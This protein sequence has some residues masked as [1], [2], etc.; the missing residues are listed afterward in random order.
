MAN[1]FKQL[2]KN[3]TDAINILKL[4]AGSS[5]QIKAKN[6]KE[7]KIIDSWLNVVDMAEENEKRQRAFSERQRDEHGKFIKK[8]DNQ[9]KQFLGMA[10]SVKSLFSSAA[11]GIKTSMTSL[12]TGITKHMSNFF[13]ALKSHVTSLFGEESEWFGILNSIKDSITGF[14]SSVIGWIWKK[15]PN[16]ASKMVK[17]LG[18]MYKLQVKEMK[19]GFLDTDKKKKKISIMGVLGTLIFAIG[20]AVG[21]FMH[22]YFVLLTKLPIFGKVAKMFTKIEGL[23]FIGKLF[24]S[25][26]FGFKILGWPLTLLLSMIDFIKGFKDME[27]TLFEKVKGGLWEA[28]TGFFELPIKFVGWVVEK[29]AGLFGVELTG[30]GDKLMEIIKSGFKLGLDFSPIHPIVEFIQGFFGTEGPFMEKIKGGFT[31]LLDAVKDTFSNWVKPILDA[32]TPI[33][34]GVVDFFK[35]IWNTMVDWITSKIPSWMPKSV[36]GTLNKMKIGEPTATINPTFKRVP[37][38]DIRYVDNEKI[39]SRLESDKKFIDSMKK[40]WSNTKEAFSNTNNAINGISNVQNNGGGGDVRQ[41]PD[42]LDSAFIGIGN[43]NGAMD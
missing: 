28:F 27:G 2:N 3:V 20:A 41:I 16:W 19:M 22:K 13:Q 18:N 10:N 23:P 25:V 11:K 36:A 33:V 32:V 17:Y 30:I 40:L 4:Y 15:T 1:D 42:E 6:E 5:G 39:K 9:A 29:V 12:V 38:N 43:H 35:N 37:I 21:A 34:S 8:Q 31:G 7:Q 14:A 26:K 24:K